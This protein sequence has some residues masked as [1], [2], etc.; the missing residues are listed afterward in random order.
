[1]PGA[2]PQGEAVGMSLIQGLKR[3]VASNASKAAVI[4]GSA[5]LSFKEVSERVNRLSNA[6]I[7]LGISPGDRVAVLALNCHRFLEFYYAVPQVGA[8]IVP[9]NFR[10]PP[11]EIKYILDHSGS[12]AVAV[13]QALT[14]VL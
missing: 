4:C 11:H 9:V 7:S 14:L 6:L 10:L 1:M 5:R 12:R 2:V 13:D 3:T 8:V